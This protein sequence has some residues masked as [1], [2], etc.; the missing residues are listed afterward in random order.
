MVFMTQIS[1]HW[2]V[3]TRPLL[4]LFRH[5]SNPLPGSSVQEGFMQQF[6][7]NFTATKPTVY[8]LV[9]GSSGEEPWLLE[10]ASKFVSSG[11]Q[12]CILKTAIQFCSDG[13]AQ[14]YSTTKLC[15]LNISHLTTNPIQQKTHPTTTSTANSL[16]PSTDHFL[17]WTAEEKCKSLYTEVCTRTTGQDFK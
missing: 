11:E 15:P 13:K 10:S 6:Q 4:H 2:L 17:V 5:H 16:C 12:R 8:S 3:F 7:R 9:C 1:H 14:F